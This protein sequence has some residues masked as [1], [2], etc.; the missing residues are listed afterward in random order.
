MY[1]Y[2]NYLV[3]FFNNSP[4]NRTDQLEYFYLKHFCKKSYEMLQDSQN[5]F[6]S[7]HFPW[8]SLLIICFKNN[9]KYFFLI[10]SFHKKNFQKNSFL[11]RTA[12]RRPLTGTVSGPPHRRLRRQTTEGVVLPQLPGDQG[13]GGEGILPTDKPA[14]HPEALFSDVST[15]CHDPQTGV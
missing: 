10:F 7:T 14:F 13:D 4:K 8:S 2:Q 11:H 15:Q 6:V 3:F 12:V 5:N 1:T 9:D